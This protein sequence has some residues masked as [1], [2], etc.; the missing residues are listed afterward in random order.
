MEI[1][2]LRALCHDNTIAMTQHALLR[3]AERGI[4][5]DDI[6]N[7]ILTGR[8]IEEYPEADACCCKLGRRIPAYHNSILSRSDTMGKRLC[9]KEGRIAMKCSKCGA[10][11]YESTTTYVFDAGNCLVIIRNVPCRKCTDCDETI[12]VGS[13][14]RKLET[15]NEI[16]IIDYRAQAA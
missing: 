1:E 16:S 7:G 5:L 9:Y 10:E 6:Q 11:T 13:V 2:K 15:M 14:I 3:I 4:S 12:F 8:I